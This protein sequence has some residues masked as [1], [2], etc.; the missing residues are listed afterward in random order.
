MKRDV[1]TQPETLAFIHAIG[2]THTT[3]Y[4]TRPLLLKGNTKTGDT[5]KKG[6]MRVT[7]GIPIHDCPNFS[8][9]CGRECY[10]IKY[11]IWN[12]GRSMDM[13]EHY[14][15]L[16][17]KKTAQLYGTLKRDIM[18]LKA[19]PM[20]IVVRV[21]DAGDFVSV[22]HVRVYAKLAMEFPEVQFFG[23]T[24]SDMAG[25][26]GRAILRMCKLP[27]VSFRESTDPSR[28]N[29]SGKLPAAHYEPKPTA[30]AMKAKYPEGYFFCPEQL[31]GPNCINC[32]LCWNKRLDHLAVV[33]KKH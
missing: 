26:I 21:H 16:A 14:S 33:F 12:I 20:P 2:E 19:Y 18:V 32:G 23:Y 29:A 22:A 1:F 8:E 24:H 6:L 15:Y 5:G 11:M 27:N 4:T 28:P 31:S 17:H 10:A 7:R 25:T 13:G 9:A 30:A 3:A